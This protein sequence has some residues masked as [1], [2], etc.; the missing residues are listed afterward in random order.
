MAK[1]FRKGNGVIYQLNR[2]F[3]DSIATTRK[4]EDKA[5]SAKDYVLKV[6]N[7]SFGIKEPVID[8]EIL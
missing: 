7:E 3:Y 6:I 1:G 4:G 5:S 8:V 2:K